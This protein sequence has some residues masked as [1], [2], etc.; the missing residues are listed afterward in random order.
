MP[1]KTGV[2]VSREGIGRPTR[3]LNPGRVSPLMRIRA[4]DKC[5][6]GI[7]KIYITLDF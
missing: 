7:R 1:A 2:E 5:R 3:Q 4:G 6:V